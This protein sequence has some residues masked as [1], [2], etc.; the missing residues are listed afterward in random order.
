MGWRPSLGAR[1]GAEGTRFRVWAPAVKSVKVVTGRPN[2]PAVSAT[3]TKSEDGIFSGLLPGIEA[4]TLYRYRLDARGPFPDPASRFQPEGV[5]GP[6]E[7]IDPGA[8]PWSDGEWPGISLENLVLYELHVG[9]FTPSGTFDGAMERLPWLADLGITAIELMPVAEFPGTHG[10]GYDGVDLFAPSHRYGRPDDLRRLVDRA[11]SLGLAVFLD[12]VYNHFGPDGNYL[13]EFSSHYLSDRH[14]TVWGTGLNFDGEHSRQVRDFLIENALHWI[15]EYHIDGL[16]LDATHAIADESPSHFLAELASRVRHSTPHRRVLLIAED[17]RNLA[18]MLRAEEEGGW[19]LDAV[20]ADDFHHQIRR[21]LAGDKE[22]YYSDFTGSLEDLATT[23]RRGWFFCGQYSKYWE[24]ERGTDSSGLPL[25]RF[26]HCLQ[27]HDQIGNRAF[28]ERLHHQ[29]DAALYRA[30]TVLLLTAPS[31]PLLFMGQEW[32]AGTPFL[33]FTD[34]EPAL[35]E[36]VTQGRREE[37]KAFSPFSDARRR[38]RIPDPQAPGTFLSSRLVW[39]EL[40]QEEHREV[41]RLYRALLRLRRSQP[42]L[43][44]ASIVSSAAREEAQPAFDVCSLDEETIG[45]LRSDGGHSVLLVVV[46]LPSRESPQAGRKEEFVRTEKLLAGLTVSG[47]QILLT[48]EDK[49]FDSHPQPL[50]IDLSG[51]A[52]AVAFRRPSAVVLLGVVS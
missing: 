25:R 39:E 16:R 45:L 33:Y 26:V 41:V 23:L 27:N 46:R 32:A 8:F 7:V 6:S 30:A 42:A 28:G 4:G 37:F 43:Q 52:P 2:S 31:T 11:H 14:E 22:G 3:L 48:T 12:V 44:F 10:W 15:H 1:P 29:I 17:H 9:A 13:L 18:Y 24:E 20:W 50:E 51:E 21:R 19:G 36:K 34:H 47:W 38:E 5:H 40:Q 35:G 49:E